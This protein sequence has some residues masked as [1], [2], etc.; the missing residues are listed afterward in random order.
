MPNEAEQ[1]RG[2][3]CYQFFVSDTSFE[4]ELDDFKFY[5]DN[6]PD[7]SDVLLMAIKN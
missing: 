1:R 2:E 5:G 4:R 7:E 3:K 6:L